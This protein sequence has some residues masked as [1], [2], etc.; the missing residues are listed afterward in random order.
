[1]DKW[2]YYVAY[3]ISRHTNHDEGLSR[4][5]QK[6]EPREGFIEY[7]RRA[8][9]K[10]REVV[11]EWCEVW[12]TAWEH[13]PPSWCIW[14]AVLENAI[15]LRV[16]KN[17]LATTHRGYCLVE[18]HLWFANPTEPPRQVFLPAQVIECWQHL[19]Y[20]NSLPYRIEA[21]VAS[22]LRQQKE[23]LRP[24]DISA[25]IEEVVG[26]IW[27]QIQVLKSTLPHFYKWL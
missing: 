4:A 23:K 3:V 16:N 22:Y 1:M 12:E 8:I 15:C 10:Y 9:E 25:L 5:V 11:H 27:P 18:C 6:Q 21:R 26:Y 2:R 17:K 14:K 24:S 7:D 20:W 19:L 13:V